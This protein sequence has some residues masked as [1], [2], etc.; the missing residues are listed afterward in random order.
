MKKCLQRDKGSAPAS[1]SDRYLSIA[2]SSIN[3]SMCGQRQALTQIKAMRPHTNESSN[4]CYKSRV[5]ARKY[6]F[7]RSY[8]ISP[9]T[10]FGITRPRPR[11]RSRRHVHYHT[12]FCS[13]RIF[14]SY[15]AKIRMSRGISYDH[16]HIN[17]EGSLH[18][19]VR[20]REDS[21][22]RESRRITITLSR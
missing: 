17:E 5:Y 19:I 22:T 1:I 9:S 13:P 14:R 11:P 8:I 6:S 21:F 15:R 7:K 12:A 20:R 10:V 4:Y 16:E 2:L 3:D 18:A